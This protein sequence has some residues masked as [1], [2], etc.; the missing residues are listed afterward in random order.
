MDWVRRGKWIS[1][2]AI[3]GQ[4]PERIAQAI[5]EAGLKACSDDRMAD[6][7]YGDVQEVPRRKR[8]AQ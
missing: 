3:V 5:S 7:E 8:D 1:E 4:L 2:T 6:D